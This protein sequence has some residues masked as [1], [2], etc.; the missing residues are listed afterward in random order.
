MSFSYRLS[1]PNIST[2]E[3]V[4]VMVKRINK[5]SKWK[6]AGII[7]ITGLGFLLHFLFSWTGNSK[8]I[9]LFVPVNESVWE[10]LKLGY[11]SVALFSIVEYPQIKQG[12]NNYFFAKTIG[13]LALEITIVIIFYG[14]TLIAGKDIFLI[15]ILSYILGVILCEYFTYNFFTLKPFSFPAQNLSLLTLISIGIL[16]GVATYYPPHFKLFLDNNNNTYGINQEK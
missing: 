2:A 15:D 14:Y 13:V 5:L 12:I 16:F 7:M 8:I 10:H 11:W 4:T 1:P 6:I 9:G 3:N